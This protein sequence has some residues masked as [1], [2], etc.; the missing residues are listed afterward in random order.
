MFVYCKD[1]RAL[2]ISSSSVSLQVKVG[3]SMNGIALTSIGGFTLG[4]LQTTSNRV[5]SKS[6]PD[7]DAGFSL[8]M[9]P[10]YVVVTRVQNWMAGVRSA[11]RC[12]AHTRYMSGN[13]SLAPQLKACVALMRMTNVE[14]EQVC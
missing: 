14:K 13:F 2:P 8:R 4:L 12:Q 6:R 11:G 5:R 10:A 3:R 1:S 7:V 9:L